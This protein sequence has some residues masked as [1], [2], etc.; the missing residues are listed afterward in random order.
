MAWQEW[1]SGRWTNIYS[2][3]GYNLEVLWYYRRDPIANKGEY[4]VA[5]IKITGKSNHYTQSRGHTSVGIGVLSDIKSE[6][7]GQDMWMSGPNGSIT[8][9]LPNV[10]RVFSFEP[11]G[12][13][14]DEKNIWGKVYANVPASPNL[15]PNKWYT[16]DVRAWIPNIDRRAPDLTLSV[17]SEDITSATIKMT[18]NMGSAM[19]SWRVKGTSAWNYFDSPKELAGSGGGTANYTVKGLKEATTQ[20]LEFRVRRTYNEVW[21][22]SVFVTVTTKTGQAKIDYNDKG[23]WGKGRLWSNVP[24][25]MKNRKVYANVNGQWKPSKS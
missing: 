5:K 9:D 6:K 7:S 13:I 25:W 17:V 12:T 8:Y 11:D 20:T 4:E 15:P 16:K 18:C 24:P 22:N 23:T 19:A 2:G 21:S 14:K 3:K 10:G 1:D